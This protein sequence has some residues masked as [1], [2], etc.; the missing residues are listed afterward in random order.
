MIAT[1]LRAQLAAIEEQERALSLEK[2]RV[3]LAIEEAEGRPQSI[4]ARFARAALAHDLDAMTAIHV[5]QLTA[6]R[7]DF[8]ALPDE[9][10]RQRALAAAEA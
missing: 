6:Y 1:D 5:E 3:Y 4:E 2:S 9:D 8:G 10:V 7:R